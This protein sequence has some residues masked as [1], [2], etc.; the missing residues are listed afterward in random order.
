MKIVIL[1]AGV[2]GVSAAWELARRGHEVTVIEREPGAGLL[3]SFAN[4]AQVT[5][6]EAV[7]WASPASLR[8]ALGWLGRRDAPFRLRLRADPSQWSWL[9]RFLACCTH[10]AFE[11]NAPAMVGLAVLSR[12]RLEAIRG[13]SGIRYDA[14]QR[15]VMRVFSDK[16]A[17][18]EEAGHLQHLMDE[19]G[20]EVR[21]LDGAGCVEAEPALQDAVG[22][23]RVVAGLWAPGDETGDAH[24]YTVGLAAAAADAGVRIRYGET[25]TDLIRRG[26]RVRGVATDRDDYFGDAVVVALGLDSVPLLRS[27][28]LQLPIY[29]MKGYS[30]TVPVGGSNLAPTVSV[31]DQSGRFVVSRLG[32]RVRV[33]GKA[34]IVGFDRSIDPVRSQD[35]VN[36][37]FGLYPN[38]GDRARAEIWTGL[39]PMTPSGVPLI[40]RTEMEGLWLDTGHGSLGWTMASGSAS[41][42]ADLMEGR[43]PAIDPAPFDPVRRM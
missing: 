30:A 36:D 25:V 26:D 33:A 24:A 43:R 9:L 27:V 7:P 14:L 2:V 5:L 10:A 15:G 28:G 3:T 32:D 42:L 4:G 20:I 31:T 23:G 34:D 13:E 8:L 12:A 1:G 17:A 18:H 41:V 21:R 11:R 37:L 16:A 35:V 6:S 38:V 40:G 19:H 39:R 22:S 29:P